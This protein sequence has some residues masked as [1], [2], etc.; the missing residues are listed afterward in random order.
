MSE[1][2]VSEMEQII[3]E[4]KVLLRLDLPIV[5]EWCDTQYWEKDMD[6]FETGWIGSSLCDSRKSKDKLIDLLHHG[7]WS[8]S[9][10]ENS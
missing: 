7:L 4:V 10:N 3:D 1:Y 8:K 6:E 2:S 5:L 9:K